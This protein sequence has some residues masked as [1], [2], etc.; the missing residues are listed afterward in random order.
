MKVYAKKLYYKS[1][2]RSEPPAR[3]SAR[4]PKGIGTDVHAT[5]RLA[6]ILKKHK[7]L[8]KGI[9][10]HEMEEIKAWGKGKTNSHRF[11]SSKE[12]RVTRKLGGERAFWKE[13][14]RRDK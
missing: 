1:N 5:I 10:K 4:Q 3:Y 2:R 14:D 8:R 9:L 11:A 7:D 12:P 6:P 13:I